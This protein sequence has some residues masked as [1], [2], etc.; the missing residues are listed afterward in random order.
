[1]GG[2]L[3]VGPYA[4]FEG[5]PELRLVRRADDVVAL[6]FERW[7]EEEPLVLELELLVLFADTALAQRDELLALGERA[8]GDRPFLES[9][10]HREGSLGD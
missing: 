1:M 9:D 8:D 6:M 5:A 10:W 2:R 7:E 4:L 3:G